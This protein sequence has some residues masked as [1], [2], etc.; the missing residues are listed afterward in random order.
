[1]AEKSPIVEQLIDEFGGPVTG[2]SANVS[3]MPACARYRI[4]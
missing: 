4:S 2:T 1:M 3:G